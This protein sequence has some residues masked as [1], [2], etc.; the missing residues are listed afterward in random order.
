MKG[1]LRT[2]VALV[3]TAMMLTSCGGN[4]GTTTSGSQTSGSTAAEPV[5]MKL[6]LSF[7]D[8][9]LITQELYAMSDAVKERTNGGI[10]IEIYA[11]SLLGKETE[12]YEQLYMGTIDMAL[13]TIAFQSTTHPE[14]TIEAVAFSCGFSI[15][16]TF[17]R[18][19]RRQWGISPAE[20][21]KMAESQRA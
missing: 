13:E 20:Y 7:A 12:M 15:P 14:L 16:S 9:H 21:R 10:N 18:L 6:G 11:D 3:M 8:S 5:T 17:Y 4:S 2:L 1:K 19:F